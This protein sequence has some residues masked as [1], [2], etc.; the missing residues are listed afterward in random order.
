MA[1]NERVKKTVYIYLSF[2][3]VMVLVGI[4]VSVLPGPP[5]VTGGAGEAPAQT[6]D[7]PTE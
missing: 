4:A 2:V 7:A 6:D 5:D 1:M 3:V